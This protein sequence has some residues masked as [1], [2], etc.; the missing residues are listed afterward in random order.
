MQDIDQQPTSVP[1]IF[2]FNPDIEESRLE[3]QEASKYILAKSYFDCREYDRCAAVFLPSGISARPLSTV[4]ADVA[5]QATTKTGKGKGKESDSGVL[6]GDLRPGNVFPQLSQKALF[7]AL[8]AKYISGEKK[9]KEESEMILG[10]AD[11]GTT[12]NKELVGLQRNLEGWFLDREAK[13]KHLSSQGWLEYL[14]GVVLIKGKSEEEGKK[15]LVKSVR[16]CPYNWDAWLE[17]SG[18]L[19]N[20]E[21]VRCRYPLWKCINAL[22]LHQIRREL[23]QNLISSIFHIY[24]CQELFQLDDRVFDQLSDLEQIF[25]ESLFLKTQRALLFYHSKGSSYR[26]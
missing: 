25:P 23:P 9:R 5:T 6:I 19:N 11:G 17:L 22:Q 16:L 15:S 8:Y 18:L 26:I 20:A 24:A 10:P 3:A 2:S 13:G 4:S 1:K 14:Y 21:D 12:I 7:M